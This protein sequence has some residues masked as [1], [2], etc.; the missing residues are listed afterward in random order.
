MPRQIEC[1]RCHKKFDRPPRR[2]I[3]NGVNSGREI[4]KAECPFCGYENK[5]QVN[6][7]GRAS[8]I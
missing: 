3:N 4:Q 7:H 6:K 5:Y 1:F 2:N 8:R